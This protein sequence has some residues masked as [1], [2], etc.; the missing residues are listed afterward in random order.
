M[1]IGFSLILLGNIVGKH[2]ADD[3]M[4]KVIVGS[5]SGKVGIEMLDGVI[6]M[7][8]HVDLGVVAVFKRLS[9]LVRTILG[10]LGGSEDSGDRKEVEGIRG[11]R[12][13]PSLH[14]GNNRGI[15][16]DALNHI[17]TNDISSLTKHRQDPAM[18]RQALHV[19]NEH[20]SSVNIRIMQI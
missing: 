3:G 9:V 10:N 6:D 2:S 12:L 16:C 8:L 4:A 13:L 20:L 17:L 1:S 15:R 7:I 11:G 18:G 5:V 14:I 19:I